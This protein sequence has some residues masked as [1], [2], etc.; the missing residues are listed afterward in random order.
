MIA[1]LLFANL[2]SDSRLQNAL[3]ISQIVDV[4]AGG[5]LIS[6]L[7]SLRPSATLRLY[8]FYST[9]NR[10]DAEERRER[11][12]VLQSKPLTVYFGTLSCLRELH[13]VKLNLPT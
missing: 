8:C 3:R 5:V 7:R 9:F 4:L 10:R 11:R 12:E 2:N 13:Y 6:T 1:G